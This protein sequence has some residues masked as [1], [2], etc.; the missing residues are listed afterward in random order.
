MKEFDDI[1]VLEF[2][3][4]GTIDRDSMTE[5]DHLAV[6]VWACGGDMP[7]PRVL[8]EFAEKCREIKAMEQ[9]RKCLT[10]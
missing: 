1:N 4:L 6:S 10:N 9:G 3:K 5:Y 8:E 2:A 7:T